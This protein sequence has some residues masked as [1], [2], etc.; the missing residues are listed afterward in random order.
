[1]IVT[2][3]LAKI[4]LIGFLLKKGG[5]G[6][7]TLDRAANSEGV[8]RNKSPG[9]LSTGYPQLMSINYINS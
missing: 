9:E 8:S 2:L 3:K 5:L 6:V 4:S 1:M 7:E